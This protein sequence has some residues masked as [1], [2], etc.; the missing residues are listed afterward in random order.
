L[1]P[2]IPLAEETKSDEKALMV[3][4]TLMPHRKIVKESVQKNPTQH[5][6]WLLAAFPFTKSKK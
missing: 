6:K 1:N 2:L 3:I 5:I 4:G